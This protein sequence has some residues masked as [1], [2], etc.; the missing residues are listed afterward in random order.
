MQKRMEEILKLVKLSTNVENLVGIR[1]EVVGS[2][3]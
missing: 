1:K 2:L 3:Q